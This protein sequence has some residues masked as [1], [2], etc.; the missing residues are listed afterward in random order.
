MEKV[1]FVID[2]FAFFLFILF[3]WH[4]FGIEFI[5]WIGQHG[6]DLEHLSSSFTV[7]RSDQWSVDVQEASGLEEKMRGK[8]Q[9]V[10]DSGDSTDQVRSWSEMSDGP[11]KLSG[12]EFFGKFVVLLVT[13]TADHNVVLDRV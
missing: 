6:R 4:F 10:T 3:L 7:R 1:F 8:G 5:M 9:S 13:H 12:M 11:Q 2:N